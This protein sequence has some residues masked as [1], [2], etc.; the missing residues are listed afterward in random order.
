[1]LIIRNLS[2][3]VILGSVALCACVVDSQPT[4]NPFDGETA[5]STSY[6]KSTQ[7]LQAYL[8]KAHTSPLD[9]LSPDAKRRF[10][11]SLVFTRFGLASYQYTDL[12]AL[13]EME[14]AQILGLF[15]PASVTDKTTSGTVPPPQAFVEYWC[16]PSQGG[17]V[18][19]SEHICETLTCRQQ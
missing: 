3:F 1:M 10:L 13:P 7:D 15:K 12:K 6:I 19:K 16:A 8:Q 9:R 17:C 11:N 18:A 4:D 5:Q 14:A 2:L